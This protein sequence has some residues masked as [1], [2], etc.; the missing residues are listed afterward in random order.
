MYHAL[1][2]FK[3]SL[4]KRCGTA[5]EEE[6]DTELEKQ[7][8]S[9]DEPVKD[10][11]NRVFL[12]LTE[13]GWITKVGKMPVCAIQCWNVQENYMIDIVSVIWRDMLHVSF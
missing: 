5:L 13:K 7:E 9:D 2:H 10:T 6:K 8:G 11:V 1:K 4:F 12:K 3:Y